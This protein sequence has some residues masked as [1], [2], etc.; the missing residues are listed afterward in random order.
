MTVETQTS[1]SLRKLCWLVLF[2]IA[3]G[4]LEAAVVVYLRDIYYPAGFDFPLAPIR[5]RDLMTE[6]GR[7]AAT[8]IMLVGIGIVAGKTKLQKIS[9]FLIAFGIWD[10]FYYVFLK[11]ILDWPT[12]L[13][14]RDILF[15]L[16]IPWVGPVLCPCILSLSMILLSSILLYK[17]KKVPGFHVPTIYWFW[18]IAGSLIVIISFCV[19]PI[20]HLSAFSPD[21]MSTY[22]PGKFDWWLFALGEL[23]L[24]IGMGGLLRRKS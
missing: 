6:L 15:L 24:L 4:Y 18:F 12:S 9:F 19:D 2:S 21:A 7:E 20:R 8:L 11:L 10:I 23:E 3:M 22:I 14:S 5:T 1:V 16:P 13:L 17:E